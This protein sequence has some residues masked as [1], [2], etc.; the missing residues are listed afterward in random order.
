ME[1]FKLNEQYNSR[2]ENKYWKKKKRRKSE[3]RFTVDTNK[4]MQKLDEMIEK[5]VDS[6]KGKTWKKTIFQ[7]Y[8]WSSVQIQLENIKNSE[9]RIYFQK[10]RNQRTNNT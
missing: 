8:V 1:K 7:I 10:I 5:K 3:E 6:W 9:Q 4:A 2:P